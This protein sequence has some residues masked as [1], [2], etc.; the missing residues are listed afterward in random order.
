VRA[1][2]VIG[3]GDW[4][5][6]RLIPDCIRSLAE[7]EPV[8]IRN[9]NAVRPWQHVLEPLSGYLWLGAL[10]QEIPSKHGSGWNFGPPTNE[11]FPV[12]EVVAQFIDNWGEGQW[13]VENTETDANS[14]HEAH[15]LK[16]DC[17]KAA[18]LL[19][20]RPIFTFNRTAQMTAHWY[21]AYYGNSN[22]DP[23]QYSLAQIEEYADVAKNSKLSWAN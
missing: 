21:R 14:K 3:G 10:L 11:Q 13:V 12:K 22:F 6:D 2:N 20:W 23:Y 15:F 17:S 19:H 7:N 1:G 8:L 9:P 18:K 5:L 16:L 4:A